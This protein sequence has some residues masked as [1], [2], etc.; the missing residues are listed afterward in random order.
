VDIRR[1]QHQEAQ[2]SG[3]LQAGARVAVQGVAELFGTEMGVGK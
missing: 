2:L 3:G 1:V